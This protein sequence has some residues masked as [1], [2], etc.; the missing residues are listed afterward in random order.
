MEVVYFDWGGQLVAA[1][2]LAPNL[3]SV[4]QACLDNSS[5]EVIELRANSDNN[6]QSIVA[7][8]ADGTFDAGNPTGIHRKERLSITYSLDKEFVWEVRALRKD[9]PVT[10]HQNHVLANEPRSLCLYVEPWSSVERAWTPEL[11]VKRIFWWL[12]E[13]ANGTI[14]DNEQPIEQLFFTSRYQ[15]VLPSNY[16]K[17][18]GSE[19]NELTIDIVQN[20]RNV[21]TLIGSYKSSRSDSSGPSFITVPVVLDPIENVPVEEYPHTLGQLQI[22]LEQKKSGI[23]ELLKAAVSSQVTEKGIGIEENKPVILLVATPRIRNGN[24]ER[25]DYHGFLIELQLAKLGEQLGVL[26][27]AP[28][29]KTWYKE[30]KLIESN[31]HVL[32]SE[33]WKSI[34][35]CPVS[36][37]SYPSRKEIRQYSGIS[38][39]DEGPNGIIA[40]VG[41]LG[42]MLA[43]IWGRECWGEWAYIDDDILKPHNITRHI[44]SHSYVGLPKST[45]VGTMVANIHDFDNDNLIQHVE[46]SVISDA[47]DVVNLIRRSELLVDATTTLN[48][49]REISKKNNYPRTANVFI[50]PSGM[51]AVLLL[52]DNERT[53]RCNSLE[54]QYYRAI[55]SNEWGE[56]HLS[57]HL[58]KL[59]L[60]AGCREATV[61]ISDE[62][63]HLHA[64][65]L[66]RQIRK[67]FSK[68]TAKI[69][70][71]DYQEDSG[72]ITPHDIVVFPAKSKVISGW[73]VCWDDG[74][75]MEANRFRDESLPNETGGV[76]LG[77]VDQKDKTI[78]LVKACNAPEES[79]STPTSFERG[80][81]KSKQLLTNCLE[82]TGGIVTYV[83][84]WHSH[85]KGCLPQQSQADIHQLDFV[86]TALK[87][88]G[89]PALMLIISDTSFA[90]YIDGDGA[91]I[92]FN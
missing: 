8:F 27:Q 31:Q 72:G 73:K 91:E 92:D 48:V 1:E 86:T 85:P 41:A 39:E 76:L 69:C 44:A 18:Q 50:T 34:S 32:E 37:S 49:P 87:E 82:R 58:G 20:N 80:E 64:A 33:Q 23:V 74:F 11:F 4:Y 60:G 19:V 3:Q 67:N 65:I 45:T 42:G 81:Y 7:D 71:W 46:G 47:P 26:C 17:E 29:Q 43:K 5:V 30:V 66:S 22:Q 52:E 15:L 90:Y 79:I 63:I 83:G 84:E 9:F 54:A 40:G 10:V 51:S 13:T 38:R 16:L 78:T 14:H 61:T 56:S 28:G 89:L 68:G 88:D 53:I 75:I 62:L 6:T 77:I 55:L 12:R 70:V 21:T 2:I 57:G 35:I 24:V 59:W 36:V 25:V